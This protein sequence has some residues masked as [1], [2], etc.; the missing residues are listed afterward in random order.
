MKHWKSLI[1]QKIREAMERG[2]L[3]DLPGK[4]TP[5]DTSEHP[6][7]DPEMRLPPNV[8]KRRPCAALD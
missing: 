5:I 7:E 3:D 2:E 4:G 1:D 6:F 8:T